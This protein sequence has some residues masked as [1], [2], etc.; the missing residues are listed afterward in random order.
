MLIC[1]RQGA[2]KRVPDLDQIVL[3]RPFLHLLAVVVPHRVGLLKRGRRLGGLL[4]RQGTPALTL[5]G[6]VAT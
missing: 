6:I 4:A 2:H 1:R 3:A 5:L